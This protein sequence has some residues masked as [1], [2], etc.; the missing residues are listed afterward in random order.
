MRGMDID[1]SGEVWVY[2][3]ASHKTM[4]H[5]RERVI[6]LGPKARVIL[7]PFLGRDPG[8]YLFDPRDAVASRNLARKQARKTPVPTSPVKRKPKRHPKRRPRRQYDKNAYGQAIR[9]GCAKAGVPLW[10]PNQLRHNVA[11][12]IRQQYGIEA[13]RQLLGHR[14]IAVTEVYAEADACR[15][16][17]IMAEAG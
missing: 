9:R 16:V 15:V 5:G 2:R 4:H 17:R 11:T 3:P 1:R 13:A 7:E 12:R 8:D 6:P 14:S 10:H